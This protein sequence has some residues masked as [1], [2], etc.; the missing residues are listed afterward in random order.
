MQ[1]ILFSFPF[2]KWNFTAPINNAGILLIL[3]GILLILLIAKKCDLTQECNRF[4][5]IVLPY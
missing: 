1:I 3:I 5:M 2:K 4:H